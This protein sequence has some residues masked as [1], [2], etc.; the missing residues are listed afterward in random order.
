LLD[1]AAALAEKHAREAGD[2]AYR[3]PVDLRMYNMRH[4]A[5]ALM[6]Y[7]G[8]ALEVARE[9]MGHSSIRLTADTY[10][11]IYPSMQRDV[12]VRLEALFEDIR[13]GAA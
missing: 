9:R 3:F 13:K 11:H 12:A 6:G 7:A 10:V 8:I 1:K 2:P 5:N 4:T